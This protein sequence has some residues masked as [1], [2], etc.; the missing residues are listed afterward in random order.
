MQSSV[1]RCKSM[2]G[3][4]GQ[5]SAAATGGNGAAQGSTRAFDCEAWLGDGRERG[6]P[7]CIRAQFLRG[8]MRIPKCKDCLGS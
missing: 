3:N 6:R 5:C 7:A 1:T 2:Q 8:R 4:V